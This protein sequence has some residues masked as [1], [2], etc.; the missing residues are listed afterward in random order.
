MRI[1]IAGGHPYLPQIAGGSQSNTNEMAHELLARGHDVAV[2]A[3]LSGGDWISLR[4][5]V[6]MKATG[7]H[8]ARDNGQGYPVFRAW[9]AAQVAEEVARRWRPDAV[10]AQPGQVIAIARAFHEAGVPTVAYFHNVEFDDHGG[11]VSDVATLPFVANS[12]FTAREYRKAFGIET[13][14]IPPLFQPE[15]YTVTSSRERVLFVNPHPLKGV[16]LALAVAARCPEIGFDFVE[17]W[18]LSKEHRAALRSEAMR[19]GNVTIYAR[20]PDMRAHYGRARVV[21][22]PS[23]WAETWG[24]VA[25]EAHYSG[26]PVIATSIGGL[27]EAVGPG[28]ILMDPEAGADEWT[29]ALSGLWHDQA[30]YEDAAAA[31]LRYAGRREID[32]SVQIDQIEAVLQ[33]AIG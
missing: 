22:V 14:V 31:A 6:A 32:R 28:G 13:T 29:H 17:S 25:S 7:R 10:I 12:Q 11:A 3:G 16:D 30:R 5:R 21:M 26:I 18:T 27:V 2:L 33:A 23:R 8:I 9:H 4:S 24:R 1:L 15:R 19:L 20:T